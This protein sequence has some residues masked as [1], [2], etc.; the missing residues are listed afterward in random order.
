LVDSNLLVIVD[1][2]DS[3][4]VLRWATWSQYTSS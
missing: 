2:G 1:G 3:S 4:P